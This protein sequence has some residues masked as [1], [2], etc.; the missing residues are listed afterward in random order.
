MEVVKFTREEFVEAVKEAERE[1][2]ESHDDSQE[3]CLGGE[4]S[5]DDVG[6]IV[7]AIV[8]EGASVEVITVPARETDEYDNEA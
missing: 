6:L 2:R 4:L 8:P 1:W 5:D 3:P 7:H